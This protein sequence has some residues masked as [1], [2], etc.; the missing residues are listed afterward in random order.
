MESSSPHSGDSQ[1]FTADSSSKRFH[2]FK[3][4]LSRIPK[5]ALPLVFILLAIP[6]TIIL[7][8]TTE[9]FFNHAAGPTNHNLVMGIST[10]EGSGHDEATMI[11]AIENLN[12]PVA[13]GGIGSYPATYSIW[14]SPGANGIRTFPHTDLLNELDHNNITPVIFMET[15]GVSPV[16]GESNDSIAKGSLD[17]FFRNWAQGAAAYP[18]T[19]ILRYDQEM[20]L[21]WAPWAPADLSGNPKHYTVLNTPANYKAAWIHMYNIIHPIAPNVKF[22]WAPY[23]GRGM[24]DFYPGDSYVDY[25]GFDSYVRSN[26]PNSM[27]STYLDALNVL[28]TINP[29]KDIIVAETGILNTLAANKRNSWIANGYPDIF[30][31]YSNH[32]VAGVLYFNI[33]LTAPEGVS[34]VFDNNMRNTYATLLQ[35]PRFQGSFSNTSGGSPTPT[36]VPSSTPTPTRLPTSTPTPTPAPT[37]TPTPTHAP[38]PTPAPLAGDYDQNGFVNKADYDVWFAE[39][40]AESTGTVTSRL[41]DGNNDG[42]IDLLDYQI[43]LN[44]YHP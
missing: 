39:Y 42:V 20:N 16:D 21:S 5:K 30:N 23:Q 27:K 1:V 37:S 11:K 26:P 32:H 6:V 43:W 24:A 13:Q 18:N 29:N 12:K 7:A 19:V 25:L 40:T 35:D 31:D 17:D 2:F 22:L 44:N 4:P 41:S 14:T 36:R 38:T 15:D 3:N 10:L 28:K 9:T 33:D 34:W 8:L